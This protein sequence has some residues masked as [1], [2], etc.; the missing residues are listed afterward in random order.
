MT[1]DP[2]P[3]EA[4]T[5]IFV[6][7][8]GEVIFNIL[9]ILIAAGALYVSWLAYRN[10]KNAPAVERQN[11]N[12]DA[13]RDALTEAVSYLD[14]MRNAIASG[15]DPDE[16]PGTLSRIASELEKYGPR[17]PEH[18]DIEGVHINILG[19][20]SKLT[21]YEGR[22]VQVSAHRWMADSSRKLDASNADAA[23]QELA[24]QEKAANAAFDELRE[25]I[26]TAKDSASQMIDQMNKR[27]RGEK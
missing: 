26:K 14:T 22:Q 7:L 11:L 2:T 16:E 21:T 17:L 3:T 24:R 27:D 8:S 1:P 25:S 6:G 12:R 15:M 13:V 19:V 10:S 20:Y 23:K 18:V 5:E 4:G 9:T